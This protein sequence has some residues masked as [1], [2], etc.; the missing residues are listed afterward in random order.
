MAIKVRDFVKSVRESIKW[1]R[2]WIGEIW[3]AIKSNNKAKEL[4]E[5]LIIS[6]SQKE[7]SK[8][9]WEKMSPSTLKWELEW[10]FL[11]DKTK[12]YLAIKKEVR[13]KLNK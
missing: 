11:S 7:Y 5:K 8:K 4:K 3:E 13:K 1:A 2:E 6:N 9:Y 12:D 10:W